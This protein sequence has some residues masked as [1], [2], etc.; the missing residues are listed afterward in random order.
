[1]ALLCSMAAW[2]QAP[3]PTGRMPGPSGLEKNE[4]YVGYLGAFNDWGTSRFNYNTQGAAMS[5][6]RS[7][8]RHW[9]LFGFAEASANGDWDVRYYAFRGGARYLF[10]PSHRFHPFLTASVGD[11]HLKGITATLTPTGRQF[12]SHSWNGFTGGGSGGVQFRI[13]EHFGV[14]AEGG[15]YRVPFGIHKY[16]RDYW[17]EATA[18][19]T[20]HF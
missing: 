14:K 9:G 3:V 6:T 11:A 13:S 2:A 20:I 19:F 17:S 15:Y 7:M 5:Y 1:M 10:M 16:D 8:N 12:L 4:I 18:G